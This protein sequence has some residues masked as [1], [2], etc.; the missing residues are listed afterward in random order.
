MEQGFSLSLDEKLGSPRTFLVNIKN[1]KVLCQFKLQNTSPVWKLEC[2][3]PDN[4]DFKVSNVGAKGRLLKNA[5][6]GQ[7]DYF[8]L[9]VT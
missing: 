7:I 1:F 6:L 9:K 5:P 3:D 8:E 4:I 2:L